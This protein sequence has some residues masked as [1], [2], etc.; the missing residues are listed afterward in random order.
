[1][2]EASINFATCKKFLISQG[3]RASKE[4]VLIFQ[5]LINEKCKEIS[6]QLTEVAKNHNSKTILEKHFEEL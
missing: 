6:N 3:M 5:K 1:M 2:T 4:S